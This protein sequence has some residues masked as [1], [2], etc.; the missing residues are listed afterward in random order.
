MILIDSSAWIEYLRNTGSNVCLCVEIALERDIATC[1]AIRMEVLAGAR[2]EHHLWA[3]SKI[4]KMAV[5]LSIEPE[6]YEDAAALFRRCRIKGETV[7]K[8]INC[9]IAAVAI[10]N[11]VPVLHNNKDFD[12]LARHSE[13][14]AIEIITFQR[15]LPRSEVQSI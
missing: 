9:L 14:K 5:V 6:D 11:N 2:N 3:L 13:L 12:V 10:R 1:G 4:L 15:Q 8:L 7:R